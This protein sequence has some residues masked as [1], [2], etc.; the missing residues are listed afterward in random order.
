[1]PLACDQE[2]ALNMPAY[3]R[4][5]DE[6][7]QF[8]RCERAFRWC[9]SFGGTS[10]APETRR[11]TL[12]TV[13]C[14]ICLDAF[15]CVQTAGHEP[16][17]AIRIAKSQALKTCQ[18]HIKTQDGYKPDK[19]KRELERFRCKLWLLTQWFL[20]VFHFTPAVRIVQLGSCRTRPT[21]S[22]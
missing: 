7:H 8:L 13:R 19:S 11:V 1:M 10:M 16:T 5:F 17:H 9:F 22:E 6:A 15:S 21:I 14:D 2:F 20:Q 18:S 3:E 4:A 12:S